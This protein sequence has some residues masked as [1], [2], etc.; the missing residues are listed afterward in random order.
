MNQA[1]LFEI[2]EEPK[3]G[4]S[5]EELEALSDTRGSCGEG[6]RAYKMWK[7]YDRL[8][9]FLRFRLEGNCY[10]A[11]CAPDYCILPL[12]GDHFLRRFGETSWRIIDEKHGM[13]LRRE[14]GKPPVL[15]RI[16]RNPRET[17]GGEGRENGETDAWEKLWKNYHRSVNNESRVNPALQRQFMPRR[18]WKYLPEM[19]P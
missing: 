1:E 16:P 17:A 14:K 10:T 5:L 12:L 7:E 11:R 19:E 9:G 15:E 18:Y 6:D 2:P 4:I 8:R 13:V 3:D